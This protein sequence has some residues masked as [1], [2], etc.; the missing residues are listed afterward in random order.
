[1]KNVIFASAVACAAV[2]A[3][4][5]AGKER[6][7]ATARGESAVKVRIEKPVAMEFTDSLK[8]Q[9]TIIAK[10]TVAVS[11]RV[12]GNLDAIWVDEGDAVVAGETVLFQIDPVSLSNQVTVAEQALAVAKS[13]LAVSEAGFKKTE[14][15]AAKAQLDYDRYGRLRDEGS[16]TANEFELRHTQQLA[17]QAG[18]AVG[19]AQIELAKQ[20][21]EQAEA[22]LQIARKSLADSRVVAPITGIVSARSAE[23]GEFIGAGRPIIQIV[24][25]TELEAAAFL[26]ARHFARV[27]AGATAF[28]LLESGRD[29]GKFDVTYK[30][31]VVDTTL[32]TFEVKGRVAG[33]AAGLAPGMMVD[34]SI[35]FD[36]R[37]GIGV[38]SGAV[39]A[40]GG[41]DTVFVADGGRATPRAVTLGLRNGGITEITGG[42]GPDDDVI[43]EGH[44][45][46]SDG[47]A[48]DAAAGEGR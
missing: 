30:S 5:C 27:A 18:L 44:T 1:M 23:P 19:R 35:V 34:M 38:P 2:L 33:G 15:E 14:A 11:A 12:P 42:I 45:L 7:G 20:Q 16:V 39:L 37:E 17:A 21:V 25:P 40:R 36:S 28:R 9:G 46:V 41:R 24:D 6:S 3:Q 43:V 13:S 47:S 26:P 32:R 22:Q 10:N 48:V 4:G 31:P 8:V 29:L